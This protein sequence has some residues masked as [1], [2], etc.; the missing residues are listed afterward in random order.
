[1][2]RKFT[3]KALR[4]V[5]VK[6]L[7]MEFDV[8]A[9]KEQDNSHVEF[10]PD[11]IPKVVDGSGDTPGPNHKENIGRTWLAAQLSGGVQPC[12]IDIRSPIEVVSGMLPNA[13]LSPGNSILS[14]LQLLPNKDQRIVIYDQ[15][16]EQDSTNISNALREMGWNNARK[17]VGGYAEWLEFNESIQIPTANTNDKYKVGDSIIFDGKRKAYIVS[18]TENDIELWNLEDGIFTRSIDSIDH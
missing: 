17:L 15:T 18:T 6:A 3:K 16:G 12:I 5:A 2:F 1:M 14:R 11:K 10:D 13:I 9:R 8:E 4:K 7:N